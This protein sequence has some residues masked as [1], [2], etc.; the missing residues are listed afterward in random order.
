M[1]IQKLAS[2]AEIVS[3]VRDPATQPLPL[4]DIDTHDPE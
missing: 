4:G 3:A 1:D 2:T